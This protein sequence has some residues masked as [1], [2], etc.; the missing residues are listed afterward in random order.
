[1]THRTP[2]ITGLEAQKQVSIYMLTLHAHAN[3]PLSSA[4]LPTSFQQL[5]L[6]S[7]SDCDCILGG[8]YVIKVV[9]SLIAIFKKGNY[10]LVAILA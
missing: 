9:I 3:V 4:R 8:K 5:H 6:V 10:I 2:H 1:M 7:Y